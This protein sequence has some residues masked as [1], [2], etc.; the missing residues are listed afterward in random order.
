MINEKEFMDW[1]WLD[2]GVGIAG[3]A[4]ACITNNT[5]GLPKSRRMFI[6][7]GH[8]FSHHLAR[9]NEEALLG[10]TSAF[11]T[12]MVTNTMSSFDRVQRIVSTAVTFDEAKHKCLWA[13]YQ[14]MKK[15]I[16]DERQAYAWSK[17][18]TTGDDITLY[19][20]EAI[21]T[22]SYGERQWKLREGGH[23]TDEQFEDW[24]LK[25][26]ASVFEDDSGYLK[27]QKTVAWY[28]QLPKEIQKKYQVRAEGTYK[29]GRIITYKIP[30][31]GEQEKWW[32]PNPSDFSKVKKR[33]EDRLYENLVF[34]Y[35]K[36]TGQE[37]D[38]RKMT[39]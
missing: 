1:L 24:V 27:K 20:Q 30:I 15:Q 17:A 7:N 13:F 16:Q 21:P 19:E 8:R 33:Y 12:G 28:E 32:T 14:W 38:D 11:M 36:L 2:N 35:R 34:N 9:S 18:V 37:L 6:K 5:F 39:E 3:Y 31:F 10:L 4:C 23:L 22:M 26:M 25:Q 29:K